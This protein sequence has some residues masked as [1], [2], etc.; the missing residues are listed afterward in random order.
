MNFYR[1]VRARD[2]LQIFFVSAITSLLAVRFYLY[3]AGYPQIGGGN[4]HIAHMLWGGLLMLASVSILLGFI[5]RRAQQLAALLGGAGFGVF[6]DE[7]GK[8][9]TSDNNYFFKPAVGIIYA[10]FVILF[11]AFTFISRGTKFSSREQQLNA[12]MEL[13]DAVAHDMDESEKARV[14]SLLSKAD[15]NSVITKQLIKLLDGITTVPKPATNRVQKLIFKSDEL[16]QHFWHR[17][18]SDFAVKAFFIAQAVIF[19]VAILAVQYASID[20]ILAIFR[21]EITYGAWLLVGEIASAL[22]ALLIAIRGAY[23]VTSSRLAGFELLKKAVLINIF[24]TQF[25]SFSRIQFD[26]LPGFFLNVALIVVIGY[27]IHKERDLN[28][29]RGQK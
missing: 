6:I 14:R 15:Q 5:G 7:I 16:Y 4:F 1:S 25:F 13:E 29:Q 18:N 26:A 12:L 9:I 10:I 23:V 24:L 17:R 28:A 21:G 27:V 11:F 22:V 8:F 2:L 20:E 3:M 19:L